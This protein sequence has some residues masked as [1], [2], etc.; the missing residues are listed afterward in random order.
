METPTVP[1]WPTFLVFP[2]QTRRL[3]TLFPE[4]IYTFLNLFLS[5]FP[6][7]Y[8]LVLSYITS[9]LRGSFQHTCKGQVVRKQYS[10]LC[11]INSILHSHKSVLKYV[12][13]QVYEHCW[14]EA[15]EK[16][17]LSGSFQKHTAWKQGE[18]GTKGHGFFPSRVHQTPVGSCFFRSDRLP[19][20][21]FNYLTLSPPQFVITFN[22]VSGWG[23]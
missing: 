2:S 11:S 23:P 10:L 14:R 20:A 3:H 4:G 9:C 21:L 5:L 16:E 7:G 12:E 13:L 15:G 22:V 18:E 6:L 17:G 19:R 1:G 8:F